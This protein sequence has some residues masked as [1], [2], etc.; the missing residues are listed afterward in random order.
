MF[1]WVR[2]LGA[3]LPFQISYHF[4]SN[5]SILSWS[6][7]QVLFYLWIPILSRW[8]MHFKSQTYKTRTLQL[9]MS[10]GGYLLLNTFQTLP[11]VSRQC[12]HRLN[13]NIGYILKCFHQYLSDMEWTLLDLYAVALRKGASYV[14]QI[15]FSHVNYWLL[16]KFRLFVSF[17]NC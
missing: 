5:S 17:L 11:C 1:Q 14:V 12:I 15:C 16:T 6:F 3:H 8:T 2:V 10:G 4:P 9:S 13:N 7:F